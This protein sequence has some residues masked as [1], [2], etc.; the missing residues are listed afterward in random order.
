MDLLFKE[1]FKMKVEFSPLHC[2]VMKTV[3]LVN[4]VLTCYEDFLTFLIP[5]FDFEIVDLGDDV[6]SF[7]PASWPDGH[8]VRITFLAG[9]RFEVC[10]LG[11]RLVNSGEINLKI[12]DS[13]PAAPLRPYAPGSLARYLLLQA[14]I[15]FD[16]G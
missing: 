16:E 6:Y 9:G 1:A 2:A 3:L 12:R 5:D 15:A 4:S 14:G 10:E 11:F 8:D 7:H 13:C